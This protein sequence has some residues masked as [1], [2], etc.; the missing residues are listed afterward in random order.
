MDHLTALHGKI[1]LRLTEEERLAVLRRK[2][3]WTAGFAVS[4]C[5][6]VAAAYKLGISVIESGLLAFLS[7]PFT[8]ART[9]LDYG[10]EF[11]LAVLESLPLMPGILVTASL[12]CALLSLRTV[13]QQNRLLAV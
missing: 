6:S 11:L 9:I 3:I 7:L 5:M 10:S 8:D 2:R 4:G 12:W 1:M 13:A